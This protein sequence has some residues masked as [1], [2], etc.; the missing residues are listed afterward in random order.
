MFTFAACDRMT[1]HVVHEWLADYRALSPVEV[2]SFAS[3]LEHDQE[4]V[5]AL[6]TVL[7]ERNKYQE[8][9]IYSGLCV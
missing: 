5:A 4:V 8:V 3:S 6:F 7:E 1:E 9:F 2:H